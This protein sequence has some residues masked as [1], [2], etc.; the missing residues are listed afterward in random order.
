MTRTKICLALVAAGLALTACG[1]TDESANSA[2]QPAATE[3]GTVDA[4]E[5]G[6]A[7]IGRGRIESHLRFLAD[8]ALKGRMTGTP[9]YD[10]AAAYVAKQFEDIGLEAGGEDGSW[11]Q[12]VPML[13][14]RI[15]VDSAS[16]VFHQD[17]EEKAQRW[18]EDFVMGGDVVRPE[19][20]VTAEVVFAGFGIHAPDMEYSDYENIDVTGKIIA[21][22][23][24][25]ARPVPAQRARLLFVRPRQGRGSGQP[26][27]RGRDRPAIQDGPAT[28]LLETGFR[29]RGCSARHV[30]DQPVRRRRQLLS[31]DRGRCNDQRTAGRAVVQPV[32]DFLRGCARCRRCGYAVVDTPRRRGHN[33]EKNESRVDNE[34]ER[35]RHP[36]RQ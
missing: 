2:A 23:R 30:V 20:S 15:D 21:V 5:Q 35:H 27:R 31:G 8:D 32:A 29:E 12:A 36:S 11:F 10:E 7:E 24:R 18:K 25:G 13:A 3:S 33:G 4:L 19:T 22:F 28:L 9:E 6:L 1:K 26:R 16:V 17:G 34:S 14:R